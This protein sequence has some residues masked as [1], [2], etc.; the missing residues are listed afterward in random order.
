MTDR[1]NPPPVNPWQVAL[2]SL[3][4]FSYRSHDLDRYLHEITCGVSQALQADWSIVTL[5]EAAKGQIIASN[6]KLDNVET[7]FMFHASLAAEVVQSGQPFWIDDV[8][9][10]PEETRLSGYACYLGVPLRTLSGDVIGTICSFGAQP[11]QYSADTIASVEL[12]AE[13]AATAI[14]NYRLYQQQ[15]QFN[16]LLEAE[17]TRRTLELTTAQA[18]LVEQERLA[19]I[20]EFAAMIVHEIRNPLTTVQ[21]G[22]DYFAKLDLPEPAQIRLAMA[23]DEAKRL[24]HLLQEILLYSKPQVLQPTLI[25]IHT[26]IQDLFVPLQ[27]MA[28][29]ES[30]SIQYV[31]FHSP[32]HV[33]GD[34]DKLKQVFINLVRNAC[35]AVEPGDIIRWS[36]SDRLINDCSITD[37]SVPQI[38][39]SVHNGGTPIAAEVLPRLTQPFFSTK[40]QGTGLGLAIVKRIVDAHG[41]ELLIESSVSEGTTFSVRLPVSLENLH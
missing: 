24:T 34:V 9:Q 12:F 3:A 14:D 28:E 8:K 10:R 33:L 4:A 41:G 30:R 15:Q 20:G 37:H 16:A 19:T 17:V 25:E 27:S 18:K 21:M 11:Q 13:R 35:E 5:H 23:T 7:E 22:L 6:L 1:P 29:A 2:D 32:I 26:F 39:I 31:P 38:Y 36:V 40:S